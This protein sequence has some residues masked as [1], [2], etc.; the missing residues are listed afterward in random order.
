MP[1]VYLKIIS[2]YSEYKEN[3]IGHTS[4]KNIQPVIYID[5]QR[6]FSNY[7]YIFNKKWEYLIKL[8]KQ[9]HS[10]N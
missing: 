10:N 9:T 8:R 3:V 4:K 1:K 5:I 7:D 6:V 2:I